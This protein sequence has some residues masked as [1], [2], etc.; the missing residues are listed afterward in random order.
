MQRKPLPA[1]AYEIRQALRFLCRR[2]HVTGV[3]DQEIAGAD[4]VDVGVVGTDLHLDARLLRQQLEDFQPREV[5]VVVLA[6]GDQ[7]DIQAV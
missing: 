7:V 6:T 2:H 4:R 1:A 5:D 3:G